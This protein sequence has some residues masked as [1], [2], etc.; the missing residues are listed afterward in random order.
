MMTIA[1]MNIKEGE[2]KNQF[3][4]EFLT[5][6]EVGLRLIFVFCLL[7]NIVAITVYI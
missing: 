4:T 6:L 3:T 5:S 2:K 1:L 7:T